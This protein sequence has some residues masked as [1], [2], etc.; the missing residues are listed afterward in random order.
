MCPD[1]GS[2]AATVLNSSHDPEGHR[3]RRR[4]CDNCA[5]DFATIEV[6]FPFSFHEADD[7]KRHA[8]AYSS[9]IKVSEYEPSWFEFTP[10]KLT[11]R[12]KIRPG[13]K[14]EKFLAFV[15]HEGDLAAADAVLVTLRRSSKAKRCRKG[16]HVMRGRNVYTHPRGHKVCNA[17]R[18]ASANAR[19]RDH[20]SP[21]TG[22]AAR[23]AS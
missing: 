11:H 16:L 6:P 5:V 17:C 7:D 22:A 2:T 14:P 18:R 1:C 13:R 19:W 3:I 9:R 21:V 20:L 15:P 23:R 12:R 4:R 8:P 10:G